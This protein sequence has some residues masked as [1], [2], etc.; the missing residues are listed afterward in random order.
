MSDNYSPATEA[1]WPTGAVPKSSGEALD[2]LAQSFTSSEQ[3]GDGS[4]QNIAHSLGRIPRIAWVEMTSGHDGLG[5]S[6]S[7]APSVTPGAHDETNCF[8]TVTSGAT[9]IVHA[10]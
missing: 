8:Y 6:G 9:Y 7:Q 5:G 1:D 4:A 3:T 10:L 2:T